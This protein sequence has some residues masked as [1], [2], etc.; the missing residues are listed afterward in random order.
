MN[1]VGSAYQKPAP[2]L[3]K[4]FA[5][6]R[7]TAPSAEGALDFYHEPYK[8][9]PDSLPFLTLKLLKRQGIATIHYTTGPGNAERA[10][11][12]IA[13]E[14]EAAE[15]AQLAHQHFKGR[16]RSRRRSRS[17]Q[18]P[19]TGTTETKSQ[20][21][22]REAHVRFPAA[23]GGGGA[24]G[25]H[26]TW[27]DKTKGFT[28][29][30]RAR[31]QR[32]EHVTNNKDK[33]RIAQLKRENHSLKAAIEGLTKDIAELRSA[34]PSG[35]SDSLRQGRKHDDPVEVPQSVEVAEQN[36]ADEETPAPKKRALSSKVRA[37][38]KVCSELKEMMLTLQGSVNEVITRLEQIE[39][40]E[41]NTVQRLGKIEVYLNETVVPVIERECSQRLVQPGKSRVE[42]SSI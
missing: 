35:N 12:E 9:P 38:G 24:A 16:S 34:L 10:R 1:H 11:A 28:I 41:M 26:T 40:R 19:A 27:A 31:E 36:M 2:K 7:F 23:G 20:S 4:S 37:Q 25:G 13:V 39:E 29:A 18:R 8:H 6:G 30:D 5:C 3:K 15:A 14:Q 22:S 21:V 42:L 33:D 17:R 32:Q